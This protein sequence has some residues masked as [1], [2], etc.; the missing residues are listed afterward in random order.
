MSRTL[1]QE[2]DGRLQTESMSTEGGL[3]T[4]VRLRLAAIFTGHCE[5]KLC[6]LFLQAKGRV[7]LLAERSSLLNECLRVLP[8]L[9]LRIL[10]WLHTPYKMLGM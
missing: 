9:A 1:G 10:I 5:A 4:C 6:V 2:D 8:S 7:S 3:I